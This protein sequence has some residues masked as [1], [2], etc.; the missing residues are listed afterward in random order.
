MPKEPADF[1]KKKTRDVKVYVIRSQL[2]DSIYII[3]IIKPSKKI[4]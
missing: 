1:L 2:D 3:I 4:M